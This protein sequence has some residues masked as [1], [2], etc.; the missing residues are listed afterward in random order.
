MIDHPDRELLQIAP[1]GQ[2]HVRRATTTASSATEQLGDG[3]FLSGRPATCSRTIAD[4]YFFVV[5]ALA[6]VG[7]PQLV[8]RGRAPERRLLVLTV[9]S[10]CWP[11][12][13]CCGATPGSTSRLSRYMAISAAAVLTAIAARA[14]GAQL[15]AFE[16]TENGRHGESGSEKTATGPVLGSST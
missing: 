12:R 11:S 2:L 10:A 4:W 8:R 15:S 7:L 1:S 16:S 9:S 13:C 3:P 5:L 14:G 6:V